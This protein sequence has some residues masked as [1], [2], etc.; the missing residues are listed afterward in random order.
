MVAVKALLVGGL[1]GLI[2]RVLAVLRL[3]FE[4]V[5]CSV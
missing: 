4:D 5:C 1:A 2:G 3:G